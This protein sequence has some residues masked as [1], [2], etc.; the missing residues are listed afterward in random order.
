MQELLSMLLVT[1][2]FLTPN[3]LKFSQNVITEDKV[4]KFA[5][6]SNPSLREIGMDLLDHFGFLPI[7]L[8][9]FITKKI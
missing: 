2:R 8:L 5:Q 1:T 3:V 4:W 7:E 6:M 9:D